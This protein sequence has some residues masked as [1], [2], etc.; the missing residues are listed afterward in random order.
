MKNMFSHKIVRAMAIALIVVLAVQSL[1]VLR[2]YKQA[3]AHLRE[4]DPRKLQNRSETIFYFAPWEIKPGAAISRAELLEHLNDIAYRESEESVPASYTVSGK[5]L[6][7]RS[8]LPQLFPDAVLTFD[9]KR[10]SSITVDDRPVEKLFI[11]PLP[12]QNAVSYVNDDDSTSLKKDLR[13]RRFVLQPGSPPKLVVEALTSIEDK[14]F[15]SHHGVNWLT[16]T[17]RPIKTWGR[18]GGSSLT[19][20]LIK[21]NI[22]KGAKDAFWQTGFDAFD[23]K[24]SKFERKF[25]EPF[26]AL[27]AERMLSK[28]EILAAYMSMNYMG[29]VGGVDLQGFAA[30]TQ[31][32]F[33]TSLFELSDPGNP[34]D[35]SR[36]AILAG[37]VQA[38]SSYMKYVRNGEKC[39]EN[40][41]YCLNLRKRRDDVLDLMHDN[42]PEKYTA[43]LV[44]RGKAE[45]LGFV[46]AG[47]KRGERPVEADSRSF[48]R[49]AMKEGNLPPELQKLRG[50]EGEVR[51]FSS[52]DAR[53]QK[54]AVDAV[55]DAVQKLQPK[56]DRVYREQRAT[57]EVKFARAEA[58]CRLDNAGNE[59]ACD[60]LFKVRA[61]LVAVDAHTGE[62]LAMS[63]TD[64][65]SRRSP[66]SLVKPFFYLKALESGSFKGAPFTAATFIDR[67][68]DVN[69]LSEYCAEPEN[70]GGS[71]TARRQLANSWNLGACIAAQSAGLPTD[72]IG[73][74]TNSTP[75]HKLMAALGGTSGSETALLDIVQAYT[76][77]PNNGRAARV[78]AYKSAYQ[79]GD[80]S[81]QRIAFARQLPQVSFNPAATFVVTQM[82]KSVVEEGTGANFRS[83]ANLQDVQLAGKSGSGMVADL[84][85][86]NFTPRIV[87]GA[88]V[89]MSANLPELNMADNFTGGKVAASIAAMFMRA[90]S[91]QRP[92]LLK[93]QF[94]RP[95]DVV[96]RRVDPKRGC[97][98]TD[99]GGAEEF[100]IA[101]REPGHCN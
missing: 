33:D 36:A 77:F 82:M 97:L 12:L 30:A 35:L 64:V 21:N 7:I 42:F 13:T 44:E 27:E 56:V 67:N 94:T 80:N 31:E 20:Q 76:H 38:P 37:M 52:L 78:T 59:R 8:R 71:G 15:M 14:R 49:Y 81:E 90:V 23:E 70:L 100:F 92:E 88:W 22:V 48:V 51:I 16:A 57:N 29:T 79:A 32:Y 73:R 65:N 34:A 54:A 47:A 89:G 26:M 5:T 87:V 95:A 4:N 85:W 96:V 69:T 60:D 53:L 66:G 84:W 99:G 93:G 46:F 68:A 17:V 19:Q 28:E 1:L 86:V 91:R 10:L 83:L 50:E 41:K 45:P 98:V 3:E 63:G 2:V 43:A 75:E 101:G 24:F 58:R 72:I 11:E 9:N 55:R 62:I 40:D 61:S 25:A 6:R 18:Q 39:A 74:A